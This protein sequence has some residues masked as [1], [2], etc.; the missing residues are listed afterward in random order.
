M[1]LR[2]SLPLPVSP[3]SGNQ[4]DRQ[5]SARRKR[6]RLPPY[7]DYSYAIMDTNRDD[8]AARANPTRRI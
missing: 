7:C 2:H 6:H 8:Q 5:G 3:E 1:D 4:R